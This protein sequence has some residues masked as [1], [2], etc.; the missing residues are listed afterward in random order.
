MQVNNNTVVEAAASE[1]DIWSPEALRIDQSALNVGAAKKLLTTVPVRKP[2]KQDFVRVHSGTDYRLTVGLI[3]L[4]ESREVYM[5]VPSVARELSESEYYLATL[6]L[7]V[8][9]TKVTTVWPV[10]VPTEGGKA[11]DWHLSAAEAAER[12]KTTW[13]RMAANMSLGAYEISE[14]IAEYGEPTWPDLP[15][16]KILK[17]AFKGRLIDTADHAV[18]QE[19]RGLA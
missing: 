15:F 19:L 16:M 5:V 3:E 4:K 13:I 8:N 2:G 12:A 1:T 6:F 7:T 17:I 11:N 9:R 10:K 18:I 14:A